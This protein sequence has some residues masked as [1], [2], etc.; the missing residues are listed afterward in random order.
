MSATLTTWARVL[1]L[2]ASALAA[3]VVLAMALGVVMILVDE[4]DHADSWDG[5]GTLIGLIVLGVGTV[6]LALLTLVAVLTRSGRRRDSAPHVV[7][8]AACAAALGLG[9][10]AWGV[11]LGS[12]GADGSAVLQA[13]LPGLALLLP[14]L[15]TLGAAVGRRAR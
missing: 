3:L 14:A 1:Q 6:H 2:V 9:W 10:V 7:V 5:F 15:G 13:G 8:A 11:G 4:L 12:E